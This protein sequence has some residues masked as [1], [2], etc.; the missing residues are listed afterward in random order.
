MTE[1]KTNVDKALM[2]NVAECFLQ[3]A[4]DNSCMDSVCNST[5]F[6]EADTG[7]L[8][9][10]GLYP[11]SVADPVKLA[12]KGWVKDD[13]VKGDTCEDIY[14]LVDPT[15]PVTD[16]ETEYY[17]ADGKS[18][19]GRW[20]HIIK[21]LG[22]KA[23]HP[24][25]PYWS[26]VTLPSKFDTGSINNVIIYDPEVYFQNTF[27]VLFS[28]NVALPTVTY[29]PASIS[30]QVDS[31]YNTTNGLVYIF[32]LGLS[33]S[34]TYGDSLSLYPIIANAISELNS[35]VNTV[36][37]VTPHN[38][39]QHLIDVY[40]QISKDFN[41]VYLPSSIPMDANT[42]VLVSGDLKYTDIRI[43]YWVINEVLSTNIC[44]TLTMFSPD[45][46]HLRVTEIIKHLDIE[47]R[48]P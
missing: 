13:Y 33:E 4:K 19:S 47:M 31:S 21:Q 9:P 17:A 7:G 8:H 43:A 40:K 38:S 37:M 44:N 3:Y 14:K 10:E 45:P 23:D 22:W 39:P 28:S 6:I 11:F 36:L 15:V 2:S 20:I 41:C 48:T 29:S 32:R 27:K 24:T 12:G 5:G 18:L 42:N 26:N 35:T 16:P 34:A 1:L 46:T 25:F 30:S